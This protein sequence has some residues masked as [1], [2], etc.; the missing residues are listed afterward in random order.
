MNTRQEQRAGGEKVQGQNRD[1]VVLVEQVEGS[2]G[3]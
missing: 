1:P 3:Q 2:S